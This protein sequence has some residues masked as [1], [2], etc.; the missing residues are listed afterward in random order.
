MLKA[1]KSWPKCKKSPNL[2]RLLASGVAHGTERLLQTSEI[3]T[4]NAVIANCYTQKFKN[5]PIP[6]SFCLFPFF[7]D[8][9]FNNT[10]WKSID[11]VLEIQTRGLRMVGADETPEL[12]RPLLSRL[13]SITLVSKFTYYRTTGSKHGLVYVQGKVHIDKLEY[14]IKNCVA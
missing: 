1:L 11:G 5:G 13:K 12:C 14:C 7:F 6:A 8:R 4:S 10:N 9:N 3:H 2:V